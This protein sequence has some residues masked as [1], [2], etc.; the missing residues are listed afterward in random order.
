MPGGMVILPVSNAC[1]E[2]RISNTKVKKKQT[3]IASPLFNASIKLMSNGNAIVQS[4]CGFD[5]VKPMF[6]YVYSNDID[7]PNPI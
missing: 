4:A 1:L 5:Q 6:L 7:R 2:N 3:P